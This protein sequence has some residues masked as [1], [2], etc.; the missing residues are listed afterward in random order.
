MRQAAVKAAG[1]GAGMTRTG[2]AV[3]GAVQTVAPVVTKNK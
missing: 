1:V 3:S 2:G